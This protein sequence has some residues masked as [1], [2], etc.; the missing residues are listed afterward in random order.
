MSM[1]AGSNSG[2]HS[3]VHVRLTSSGSCLMAWTLNSGNNGV[4]SECPADSGSGSHLH[5]SPCAMRASG[6]SMNRPRRSTPRPNGKCSPSC[7]ASA[8][9]TSPSSYPTE[10]GPCATWPGSTCSIAGGSSRRDGLMSWHGR[11]GGRVRH[12]VRRPDGVRSAGVDQRGPLTP[13]SA[14]VRSS[15]RLP[16]TG[17]V[18]PGPLSPG[19][20]AWRADRSRV[21]TRS[22]PT[23]GS[24]PPR[25]R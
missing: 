1:P 3:Q 5:A 23:W 4:A 10:P 15:R 18:R 25:T 24:C 21:R 19:R 6:S 17:C 14:T 7:T 16:R 12:A 8:Q 9:I 22:P 11:A 2:T 20:P 13:W